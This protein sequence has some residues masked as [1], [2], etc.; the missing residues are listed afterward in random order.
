MTP[1]QEVQKRI[2]PYLLGQLSDSA[3]EELEQNFL[4]NAELFEE[5]LVVEDELIDEYLA[6]KLD[7]NERANFERHFLA[8]P[9]RQEQLRF[10]QALN[11][12]VTAASHRK[13]DPRYSWQA[14]RN[15]P[16]FLFRAAAAVVLVSL[17]A[18]LVWFVLNRGSAP[19]TFATLNLTISQSTRGEG[20]QAASVNVPLSQDAL[21]I[22]LRLPDQVPR[23]ERYRV[24]LAS[25]NGQSRSLKTFAQDGQS[26]SV[27]IPASELNRGQFSLRLFTVGSDGAEQRINGNYFFTV[28]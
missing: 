22:V 4:T 3:G 21:K 6:S 7:Q 15:S 18:G 25:D 19:K 13:N 26:L 28:E 27:V 23:A 1:I 2:R 14:F 24:E 5:L 11:R 8:T 16:T 20:A 12:Y 9:E 17:I 10:A